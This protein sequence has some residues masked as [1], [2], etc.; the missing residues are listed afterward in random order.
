MCLG[1][2]VV[3]VVIEL[4]N[5]FFI[6]FCDCIVLIVFWVLNGFLLGLVCD[7]VVVFIVIELLSSFC[8]W[9]SGSIV[10]IVFRVWIGFGLVC[11]GF[12]GLRGVFGECFKL[13]IGIFWWICKVELWVM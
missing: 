3:Y 8:F 2:G 6:G 4:V 10:L 9:F 13:V 11:K 7:G 12:E 1:D 5:C